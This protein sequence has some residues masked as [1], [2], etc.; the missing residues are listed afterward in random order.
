[1]ASKSRSKNT[2]IN[3]VAG[4]GE[5]VA[6]IITGFIMRSLFI[7][8]L[9]IE[10]AGVSS[11]FTDILSALSLAELGISSAITYAL[12]KPIATKDN[13]KVAMLMNFYKRAYQLVAAIIMGVGLLLIPFLGYIVNDVPKE[14]ENQLILIYVLYLINSAVSYLIVYK[15]SLL[16][17][18]QERRY[19]SIV[20]IIGTF[21]RVI[22]EAVILFALKNVLAPTPRFIVYLASGIIMTR[23]QNYVASKV[24][25]KRYPE[26]KEHKDLKLPKEEQKK[27]YKDISALMIYKICNSLLRSVDS[28]IISVMFGTVYVGYL[29]NYTLV[30]KRIN[31]VVNQFYNSAS[32]SIGNMAAESDGEKQYKTFCTLQFMAFWMCCFCSV[33]FFVLLDPFVHLWLGSTKYILGPAICAVL[34]LNF[35]LTSIV[36]P[37]ATFRNANGLFVQGK[38]RPIVM[39]IINIVLSVIFALILG[40]N[41]ASPIWGMFGVK[42]ATSIAQIVTLHWFDPYLVYKNVFKKRF[43]LYLKTA[44]SQLGFTALCSAIVYFIGKALDGVGINPYL[45]F[46][47]KCGLCVIVPNLA[48]I[49]VYHKKSEFKD[50]IQ[51]L[52]SLIT[53]K[54]NKDSKKELNSA[55]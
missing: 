29:G 26:L 36:H 50:F 18:H 7:R 32:P 46:V 31:N 17:A 52:K 25:E 4:F 16:T 53:K 6:T 40:N 19:V 33:S 55:S 47:I 49:I 11:L 54:S 12:Y 39:S 27:I 5:K 20:N 42:I 13:E 44:I 1:M 28:I 41:G 2:L 34:S 38:Y 48:I 45:L 51:I 35:Y 22:V 14:I 3:T 10:Y 23:L 9:G 24:A 43:K 15:T 37:V 30:T 8:L 21:A